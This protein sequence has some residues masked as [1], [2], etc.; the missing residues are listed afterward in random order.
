[1]GIKR[2]VDHHV[3]VPGLL[4]SAQCFAQLRGAG[5]QQGHGLGDIA[6]GGGG[7]DAEPGGQLG[8]CLAF[9]QV[10]QHQQGLPARG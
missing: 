5:G 9:A 1:M 10:G 4:R 7:A 3:G 2:A 8:E 6:P